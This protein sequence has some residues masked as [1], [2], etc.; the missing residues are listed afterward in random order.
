MDFH[1]LLAYELSSADIKRCVK[2]VAITP[3]PNLAKVDDIHA[4]LDSKGRSVLF[5]E[6]EDKGNGQIGGHWEALWQGGDGD[7]NFFDSYG[8]APD[9][10]RK[11]LS[12][13]QLI[14]LKEHEPELSR[15]LKGVPHSYSTKRL[16]SYDQ[17]VA[18]CGRHV[19]TR[20][21]H[22]HLSNDDYVALLD[23]MKGRYGVDSYDKVVCVFTYGILKK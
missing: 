7:I 15:L 23:E 20:L 13:N 2:G 5:F 21:L 18:T 19:C 11:W 1:K 17:G 8:L 14:Q 10:C 22:R 16:Q 12:D 9:A 6:E 3:Y 4:V